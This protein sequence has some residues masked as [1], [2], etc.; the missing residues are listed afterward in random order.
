[1][2]AEE[3]FHHKRLGYFKCCIHTN[4][5]VPLEKIRMNRSARHISVDGQTVIRT[6]ANGALKYDK[7]QDIEVDIET[8]MDKWMTKTS[9]Q[10]L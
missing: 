2:D 5:N 3:R 8:T 7:Y 9:L 1:M 6:C 10:R 4:R